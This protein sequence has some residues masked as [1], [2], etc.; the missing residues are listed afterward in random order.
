M[1]H[2]VGLAV[3]E[4]QVP[5]DG[6][7]NILE[8]VKERDIFG[9]DLKNTPCP[10][11][12]DSAPP[13][14][15]IRISPGARVCKSILEQ[16]SEEIYRKLRLYVAVPVLRK[17]DEGQPIEYLSEMR[18]VTI[19]FMNLVT[20]EMPKNLQSR[21]LQDSFNIVFSCVVKMQGCLNKIFMFDK[22]CTFLVIFGLPGF[23]H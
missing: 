23:K 6:S 5:K 22:G 12:T 13:E 7:K 16:T 20:E 9:D 8:M 10:S 19:V 18:Q 3:V 11:R 4:S 17:M 14:N 21:L 2:T 15:A 1:K